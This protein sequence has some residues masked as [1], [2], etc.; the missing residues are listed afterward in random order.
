MKKNL[1]KQETKVVLFDLDNTLIS[2][3]DRFKYLAG[4]TKNGEKEFNAYH[5]KTLD[6][7]PLPAVNLYKKEMDAGKQVYIVTG[8]GESYGKMVDLWF[9]RN[10][11]P[12]PHKKFMRNEKD[13]RKAMVFKNDIIT[14]KIGKENIDYLIDDDKNIIRRLGR[15]IVVK[16]ANIF[17][18]RHVYK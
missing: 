16:D 12:V 13:Y 14:N 10:N 6:S 5:D 2:H 9:K 18:K 11:L 8:K 3:K 1:K 4:V 17:N 15:S 7:K